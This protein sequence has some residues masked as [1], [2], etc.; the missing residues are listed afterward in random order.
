MCSTSSR[1]FGVL[2]AI[3]LALAVHAPA[4]LGQVYPGKPL[5]VV[6]PAGPGSGLDARSREVAAKLSVALGQPVV[7]ENRPGAGGTIAMGI[8]AKAP[9]DGYTLAISGIGTVAYYPA[10]Y[11]TLPYAADDFV[12]VSLLATGRMAIYA[13]PSFPATS[14]QELVA[15]AKARPGAVTFAS[16]GNGTIQHLAG[17]LFKS[18]AGV[19]MLHVPYKDYGQIVA[20]VESGRVMLLFDSTGAVLPQVQAGK[21]KA[22]AVTG[23]Q[24]LRGLPDVPTFT[25]AGMP[26]FGAEI[27]Y[28]VFAPAGTPA[29]IVELLSGELA[30]IQR[31]TDIQDILSRF[32]FNSRGTT[33]AEFSTYIANE[34]E[35]W[36]GV[37]K[38][39]G[40]Q[41]DF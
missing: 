25:E 8:V 20:D 4:S 10:L 5:R 1:W 34:R 17:E 12:P 30:K 9:S 18:L 11:R 7:V 21:L 19:D 31:A 39:A 32:G 16:Q 40:L 37:V 29:A 27:N 33:P 38:K 3:L 2:L 24:R 22:L 36:I 15:F 23:A 14:I 35:R 41:L 26:A 28:G 13:G 6:I